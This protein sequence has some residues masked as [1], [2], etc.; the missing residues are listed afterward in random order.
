[1]HV[2]YVFNV[3]ISTTLA[4]QRWYNLCLSADRSILIFTV[5]SKRSS[6]KFASEQRSDIER[7]DILGEESFSGIGMGMTIDDFQNCRNSTCI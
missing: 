6:I 5:G 7:Y 3:I 2:C 4:V 1:M